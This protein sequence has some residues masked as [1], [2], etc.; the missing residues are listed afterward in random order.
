MTSYTKS[1][2]KKK[3]KKIKKQYIDPNT[4]KKE[5]LNKQREEEAEREII[6]S[7]K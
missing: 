1:L 6:D 4:T 2:W 5:K 7:W 3:L